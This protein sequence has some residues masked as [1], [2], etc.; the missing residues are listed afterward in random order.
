MQFILPGAK[1]LACKGIFET[2][3]IGIC[4]QNDRRKPSGFKNFIKFYICQLYHIHFSYSI[5][6]IIFLLIIDFLIFLWYNQI[7]DK[8][9]IKRNI[10]FKV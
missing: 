10:Y 2:P 5:V 9:D 1:M 3:S 8:N 7:G 6:F 4:G